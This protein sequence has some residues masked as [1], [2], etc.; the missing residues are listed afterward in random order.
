MLGYGSAG[1]GLSACKSLTVSLAGT[2]REGVTLEPVDGL[3]AD[4]GAV[5]E[6]VAA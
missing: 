3:Q 5:L 6:V 2:V 4:A 1:F